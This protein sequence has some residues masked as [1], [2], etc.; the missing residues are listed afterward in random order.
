MRRGLLAAQDGTTSAW[1]L[2]RSGSAQPRPRGGR[3]GGLDPSAPPRPLAAHLRGEPRAQGRGHPSGPASDR[4][5]NVATTTRY[6]HLSDA[7]LLAA[8]DG[9]LPPQRPGTGG[10]HRQQQ[11]GA[12]DGGSARRRGSSRSAEARSAR[13]TRRVPARIWD[14]GKASYSGGTA[15]MRRKRPFPTL[16]SMRPSSRMQSRTPVENSARA[17]AG[18]QASATESWPRPM[19]PDSTMA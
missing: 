14:K 18:T 11:V 1:A 5:S 9:A 15:S 10:E 4:P 13:S 2:R 7:D 12:G 19:E 17:R 3:F 6:L 16:L 8:V